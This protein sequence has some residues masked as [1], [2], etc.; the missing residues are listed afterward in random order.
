MEPLEEVTL[1]DGTTRK[2]GNL[3]PPAGF[4]SSLPTFGATDAARLIPR[5]QW[6][7]LLANYSPGPGDPFLPPV[8]DQNGVGCCNTST[9]TAALEYLR[10]RQ[11]LPYVQ[12]SA[13]DLYHRINFGRDNGSL[14]EDALR[15]VQV[16][17]VGTVQSCGYLW[18]KPGWKGPAN[19]AERGRFRLLE[20]YVC[21]TFD[22]VMSAVFQGFA[23]NTGILWYDNYTPGAD[24]WLPPPSG[25]AGGHSIFGYKPAKRSGSYGIWHM[26]SWSADWPRRGAGGL[27]V[28][29]ES[30]YAGPVGGW[31][32]VRAVVD[33]GGVIPPETN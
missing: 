22:H 17:G 18:N 28:I 4:V 7:D 3:T 20:A 5:S 33:E 6:D 29:P 13:A 12:L 30:A 24:G 27:F 21:P 23:V 31:F 9:T 10:T 26:N 16:N 15:E 32:A 8:H 19:A 14:L 25:R 1:P 2:L 11:G